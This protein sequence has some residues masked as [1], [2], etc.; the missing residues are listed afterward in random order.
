MI[1]TNIS[2]ISSIL[3]NVSFENFI[4]P[5]NESSQ[6]NETSEESDVTNNDKFAHI[7]RM[8][9]LIPPPLLVTVGTIGNTLSFYIMRRGSLKDVSTCFYMSALAVADTGK[10]DY[11]LLHP[12]SKFLSTGQKLNLSVGIY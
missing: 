8:L 3:I 11:L 4:L 5:N 2:T 6:Y 10:L 7:A 9:Q 12:F 1:L